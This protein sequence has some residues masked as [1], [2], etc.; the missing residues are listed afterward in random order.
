MV[1]A[2]R[3]DTIRLERALALAV[4]HDL[5]EVLAGDITPADGVSAEEKVRRETEALESLLQ[6]HP[7]AEELRTLWEEYNAGKSPEARFV[8]ACDKLDMALQAQ[9]YEALHP[10]LDLSE[11]VDSALRRLSDDALSDLIRA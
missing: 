8:R 10:D 6:D 2:L 4:I 7:R 9:R 3:P 5:P 1:L 11:F